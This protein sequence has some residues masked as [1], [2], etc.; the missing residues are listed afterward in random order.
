MKRLLFALLV[1]ACVVTAEVIVNDT[2]DPVDGSR[3]VVLGVSGDK[4]FP[5]AVG[6]P[7][8]SIVCQDIQR[9]NKHRLKPR[10]MLATQTIP[11]DIRGLEITN[12]WV[13]SEIR[14]EGNNDSEIMLW[15]RIPNGDPGILSTVKKKVL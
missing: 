15:F 13:Q 9:K 14:F 6:N 8:L 12:M 4:P 10:L 11:L 5:G 3:I 7:M 2:T 1:T